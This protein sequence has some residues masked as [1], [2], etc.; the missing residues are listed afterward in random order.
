[1]NRINNSILFIFIIYTYNLRY[2]QWGFDRY[3]PNGKRFPFNILF[4]DMVYS[5]T[6]NCIEQ[7]ANDINIPY[8]STTEFEFGRYTGLSNKIR[9]IA[10]GK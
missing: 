3:G 8:I 10:L 2:I 5:M 7:N 9:W 1:M 6:A 4:S